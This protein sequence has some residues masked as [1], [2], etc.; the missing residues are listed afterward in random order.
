M[1]LASCLTSK[2]VILA[3]QKQVVG[4]YTTLWKCLFKIG[5]IWGR[6]LA[7]PVEHTE[8]IMCNKEG[9]SPQSPPSGGKHSVAGISF[10]PYILL[11]IKT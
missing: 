4:I 6:I 7:H 1:S 11:S 2:G 5:I 10:S 3:T 8:V 9:S